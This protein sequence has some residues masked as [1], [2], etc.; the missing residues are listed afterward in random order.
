MS[1]SRQLFWGL[2]VTDNLTPGEMFVRARPDTGETRIA[3]FGPVTETVQVI[4]HLGPNLEVF[5]VQSGGHSPVYFC[6]SK[7]GSQGPPGPMACK[8]LPPH[9]L[10]NPVR[11]RA[12]LR[13]CLVAVQLS[14]LPGFVDC[15]ILV[16]NGMPV[17]AMPAFLRDKA[18]V[19]NMRDLLLG[20]AIP[21]PVVAF[22]GWCV[23]DSM[24]LACEYLPGLVHGDLKPENI[25]LQSGAPFIADFGLART[26]RYAWGCDVLP[27][28]PA[29]LAP[30]AQSQD[31]GLTQSTDVFAFGVMLRELLMNAF[32]DGTSALRDRIGDVAR[33]CTAADPLKR[34]GFQH[35]A[36]ELRSM[37]DDS[38][39]AVERQYQVRQILGTFSLTWSAAIPDGDLESLV[40]LEQWD[41]VLEIIE[42]RPSEKRTAHL[43]RYHGLAL[44][45]MERDEEGLRSLKTA[46][47]RAEFEIETRG[48]AIV[49]GESEAARLIFDILYD[50]AV[51]HVNTG[52][53]AEAEKIGWHLVD[54]AQTP[55]LGR[56]ASEIIAM[57]AARMGRFVE[58]DRLLA[59]AMSNEDNPERLSNIMIL[60]AELR[61]KQK[62]PGAAIEL[63]QHA[64]ELNPGRAK[65]HRFLGETLMFMLGDYFLAAVAFEHAM[66][67]GD[68]NEDVLVMRL[69]CAIL[70]AGEE[71]VEGIRAEADF[72]YGAEALS[73]AWPKALEAIDREKSSDCLNTSPSSSKGV[74]KRSSDSAD[75]HV[76]VNEAGIYSFGDLQVSVN[77]SGFYTFDFYHPIGDAEYLDRLAS[78]YSEMQFRLAGVVLRG[79]PIVFTQCI[80]C[81]DEITTNLPA[82]STFICTNC[83]FL[84]RVVP[85]TGVRYTRLLEEVDVKLGRQEDQVDGYGCC[86]IVQPRADY[87][88]LQREQV[89]TLARKHGLEPVEHSHPAVFYCYGRG[90]SRGFF[91]AQYQPIGA[92][93]RF[94]AGSRHAVQLTPAPVENYLMGVRNVFDVP[95]DSNSGRI[96]FTGS[97]V[98]SLIMNDS[99][100]QAEEAVSRHPDIRVRQHDLVLLSYLRLVRGDLESAKQ[101]AVEAVRLDS[102]DENGW[103]AKGYAE[104]MS[105]D[106]AEARLS[107]NRALELNEASSAAL[108]LLGAVQ[109]QS[110]ENPSVVWS[111]LA[112]AVT[113]G[114]LHAP[115][116]DEDR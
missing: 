37:F 30:E 22:L 58:A 28:T 87:T 65:H 93:Y 17:L 71:S 26:T 19:A 60:R 38:D 63:I 29:Y 52:D 75:Q 94:P 68:L 56:H 54:T 2:T 24:A 46:L 106:E 16:I 90:L 109:H 4:G 10:L 55:E 111:T 35:I 103:I 27:G 83:N 44:T 114:A 42:R 110:D 59:T 39:S 88:D 84:N 12:F 81:G 66:L 36:R 85:L 91:R 62:Q 98:F 57:A 72:R 48:R 45:R 41:L 31:A 18:G 67:C 100:D 3:S 50:I 1:Y 49:F 15:H 89:H 6:L 43:W 51:L 108:A 112:R 73:T 86:V 61:A 8:I 64:I 78:Q 25:L 99:L 47:A 92:I 32:N 11:R 14:A 53:Y 102:A 20:P 69:I 101:N 34:P 82:G 105:G 76:F 9:V 95:V 79:T 104:L 113:L 23:A 116:A 5:D 21:V 13:E 77:E 40:R 115:F 80:R 33:R 74:A 107:V 7:E 96:D 70:S 97:T